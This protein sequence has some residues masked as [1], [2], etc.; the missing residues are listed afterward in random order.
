MSEYAEQTDVIDPS[1]PWLTDPEQNP[2][3]QNWLATFFNPTGQSPT[4]HF[5]RA[6]TAL[7]MMQ[8]F[9][10][11][12]VGM[13][14]FVIGLAGAETDAL[15]VGSAYLAAAVYLI[16]SL[17]SVVIHIRRLNH[18]RKS[19]LWSFLVILPLAAALF[20]TMGQVT[21]SRVTYDEMYQ[22]RAEFLEDPRG[23]REA[24]L[25]R[26]RAERAEQAENQEGGERRGGRPGG[27]GPQYDPENELPSQ[28]EFVLRPHMSGFYNLILVLSILLVPWSL[29]WVARAQPKSTS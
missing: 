23:Y 21:Q 2:A 29:M 15:S 19:P 14:I 16:T 1:R 10:I 27:G 25:E 4:L 17:M 13:L 8:L 24:A 11:V 28:E 18:A 26:Q 9:S 3:N 5:T 20:V 6:W 22:S 12:G 7:F